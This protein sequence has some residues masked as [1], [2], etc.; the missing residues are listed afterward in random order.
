M[1]GMNGRMDGICLTLI[2][3]TDTELIYKLPKSYRLPNSPNNSLR[4]I[5]FSLILSAL[6]MRKLRTMLK[7]I[8]INIYYHTYLLKIY[9]L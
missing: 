8:R 1:D 4:R 3:N 7:L 9:L 5:G 2:E 6:N